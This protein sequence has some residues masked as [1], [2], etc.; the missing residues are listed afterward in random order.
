MSA[1]LFVCFVE[2]PT[3]R[4]NTTTLPSRMPAMQFITGTWGDFP[5]P[6]IVRAEAV[7][8]PKADVPSSLFGLFVVRVERVCFA[9]C[10]RAW[11]WR[12]VVA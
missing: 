5:A 2:T 9:E 12:P 8:G 7:P 6:A 4:Q 3:S 11:G 10:V 1:C